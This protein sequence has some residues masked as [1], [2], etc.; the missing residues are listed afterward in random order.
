M[1][2]CNWKK[3]K[4]FGTLITEP[5]K[6][7]IRNLCVLSSEWCQSYLIVPKTT[8]QRPRTFIKIT[9]HAIKHR[10][11][12]VILFISAAHLYLRVFNNYPMDHASSKSTNKVLGTLI[13]SYICILQAWSQIN[14]D[15]SLLSAAVLIIASPTRWVH[16]WNHLYTHK[17]Y[18]YDVI[19][20]RLWNGYASCAFLVNSQILQA[21]N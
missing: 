3:I 12:F 15:I 8:K 9:Q 5:Y 19:R 16:F 10:S 6:K 21:R 20:I 11:Y 4:K 13:L 18:T 2:P 17:I 1:E 7:K 14:F